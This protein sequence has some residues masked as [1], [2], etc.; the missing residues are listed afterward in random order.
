ML[1]APLLVCL[2]RL[3]WSAEIIAKGKRSYLFVVSKLM[4]LVL[5]YNVVWD[6]PA[7]HLV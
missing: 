7:V 6:S 3:F 4:F 1:V 2:A 5:E